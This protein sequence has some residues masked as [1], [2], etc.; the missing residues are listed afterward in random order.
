MPVHGAKHQA[1]DHQ[2]APAAAA[3]A[4]MP[5]AEAQAAGEAAAAPLRVSA[6]SNKGRPPR[7]YSPPTSSNLITIAFTFL[8]L[9]FFAA[10]A[11]AQD[12]IV[13][14]K[15]GAVAEKVGEVAVDLGSAQFPMVLRLVI[16]DTVHNNGHSCLTNLNA[17]HSF[18]KE[19][20]HLVPSWIEEPGTSNC[21]TTANRQKRSPILAAVGVAVGVSALFNLFTGSMTSKEIADI[22]EKQMRCLQSYANI[23]QRSFK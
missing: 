13:L 22:K 9:L 12:V 23:R 3:P 10:L 1:A 17:R 15:L 6:R 7:R 16:H 18:E 14:P 8:L 11:G 20:N 21:K 2:Q 19:K 5:A 4:A